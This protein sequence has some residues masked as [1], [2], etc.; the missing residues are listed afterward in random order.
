MAIGQP[1]SLQNVVE[2]LTPEFGGD[3]ASN[4]FNMMMGSTDEIQFGDTAGGDVQAV[5]DGMDLEINVISGNVEFN[6]PGAHAFRVSKVLI[7]GNAATAVGAPFF[8]INSTGSVT[9]SMLIKCIVS[10]ISTAINI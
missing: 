9:N 8:E 1:K 10:S 6:L 5:W 3:V 2:D 7:N 4:S